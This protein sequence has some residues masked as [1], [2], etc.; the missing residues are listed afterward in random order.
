MCLVLL[1]GSSG[2]FIMSVLGKSQAV[3]EASLSPPTSKVLVRSL[4]THTAQAL[5]V[6]PRFPK[7]VTHE[8]V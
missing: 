5:E 3:L 6:A 4:Y 8:T 1:R 7:R 2:K